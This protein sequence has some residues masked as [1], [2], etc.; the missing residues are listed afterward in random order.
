MCK[1]CLVH[2]NPR[3]P[4]IDPPLV[5]SQG[6]LVHMHIST[7]CTHTCRYVE[8]CAQV[9]CQ[10]PIFYFVCCCYPPRT[11]PILWTICLS[12]VHQQVIST[13][14]YYVWCFLCILLLIKTCTWQNTYMCSGVT[15]AVKYITIESVSLLIAHV[16][17]CL[18]FT[19]TSLNRPWIMLCTYLYQP[20]QILICHHNTHKLVW[21]TCGQVC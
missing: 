10:E 1:Y 17:A 15:L 20:T 21:G 9:L 8:I 14:L 11:L 6:S 4:L 19:P 5:M 13:M 18:H 16:I 3:N 12:Q 7:L 2:M